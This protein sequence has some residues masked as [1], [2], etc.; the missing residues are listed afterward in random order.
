[1]GLSEDIIKTAK[2][3]QILKESQYATVSQI[4]DTNGKE[5]IIKKYNKDYANQARSEYLYL[6]TLKGEKVVQVIDLLQQEK[7][8][9]LLEY[10]SGQTLSPGICKKTKDYETLFTHL[11]FTLAVIHSYGICIN[12]IKP[13]NLILHNNEVYISDLGLATVNLYFDRNFRGTTAYAAPEKLLRQTNHYASDVFSL[14]MTMF[15]CLYGKTILDYVEESAYHNLISSDDNWHKQIDALVKDELLKAMLTYT[16]AKRPG[17]LDI[18]LRL[19]ERNHIHFASFERIHIENYVFKP[20]VAAVEKLWKKKSLCCDYSDEP[21]IILNLLSLWAESEHKKLLILDEGVF[22]SQPDEFFKPFPFG[23]REKNIFNLGFFEWLEE[24]QLVVLLRRNKQLKPTNFFDE[25]QEKT[26]AL[27]LWIDKDSEVKSVSAPEVNEILSGIPILDKQKA[28]IKKKITSAKPFYIRLLL[29]QMLHDTSN[30]LE[31]NPLVDFLAWIRISIPL[32]LAEQVWSNWFVLVQDGLLNRKLM[33]DGNVVRTESVPSAPNAVDTELVARITDVAVKANLYNIAGEASFLS[34]KKAQAIDFWA[35]YVEELTSNQY[36]FSAYEFIQQIKHRVNEFPF[37]LKKK[38]AFLARICGHFKLSNQLYDELITASEGQI[39]AVLSVD[40]AI[41]L[42][43]LNRN[44]EAISSY[45]DAIDLFR[46]H[47]DWKSLF[48]AMNNLGVVYFGLRRYADAEQLFNEVLTQAKQ[49]DNIQFETISYLNLSDIQLKRCEW[50]RVVYFADKAIEMARSNQKWNLYSNGSIIKARAC[51]AMGESDKAISILIELK[52][53][54]KTKENLLQYQETLAWLIHFTEIYK[55]QQTDEIIQNLALDE[56]NVHEILVRELF[57]VYYSRHK[58][59][60][61]YKCLNN[62]TEVSI[63]KAIFDSD[64]D[65]IMSRLKEIKAQTDTDN[66]LYYLTHYVKLFPVKASELLPE[67]ISEAIDLYMFQPLHFLTGQQLNSQQ[68]STYWNNLI[69]TINSFDSKDDVIRNILTELQ[70]ISG[71]N[72]YAYFE[73]ENGI[74]KLRL[75]M[76]NYGKTIPEANLLLSK[77]LIERSS[78]ERGY[79]YLY[80]AY[81]YLSLDAHSSALGLGITTVC[82]YAVHIKDALSGLFYC[83]SNDNLEFDEAQHSQCKMLFYIAQNSLEKIALAQESSYESEITELE[84]VEQYSHK[85]TGNSK[86]MRDVYARISLVAGYDVNILIMGPTGSGKELVARAI[87]QQFVAKSH[88][89]AKIPFV[90]LNCAAIPEQLLESELFGFKKGAFTGAVSDKKGKLQL[91][92]NGTIF[93][94]EIGEMPLLL[95]TKLLRVIQEKVVTPLGSDQDYP[96]NVR[97]IAATNKN[98]EDMVNEKLFRADLYYRIKVVTIELPALAD[99][100]E[101]IPLLAMT[102]LRKFNEKFHKNINGIHPE[103]LHYLQTKQWKGNVRE[104][105]NEMER[106]VL[107]CSKD[108]LSLECISTEQDS[109]AGSIFRN[110]PLQWQQFKEYKQRVEDELDKRYVKALMDEADNNI[111]T[112]SKLGNLER[113][114]IYRLL[115]KKTEE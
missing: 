38:E 78:L 92:D 40:R 94:D 64:N 58:Y 25:I 42:Q 41:V 50:N 97:I 2:Q 105:E 106:A 100:K 103:T 63:I 47:Q 81:N 24:Q 70:H 56:S 53:N 104:L 67:L 34:G 7:P 1:M 23:Y 80:P 61:A 37:E 99:R 85:M 10:L 15:Y 3:I 14:G 30:T 28:E 79:A 35:Q 107:M 87:H 89:K 21:L 108:Y 75:A 55:P 17:M 66:Y 112:A 109:G 71:A 60:H 113:M 8:I 31:S 9:I 46:I 18:A 12:D 77:K 59:A 95:Q 26:G 96:V 5:Y 74:P 73:F 39:K 110:L 102:F 45:K 86:V 101:D 115:K 72:T 91:A 68:V 33:L 49:K 69:N 4:K 57:F 62:L 44:E 36:F 52:D 90:P 16:P 20:Q 43:A 114:Q 65:A 76:D 98:L 84:E 22:I 11:A 32:V 93:L 48:R 27:Q 111:M 54:H 29:L 51:F 83:D 82:S 19:A 13:D 6:Q 88:S